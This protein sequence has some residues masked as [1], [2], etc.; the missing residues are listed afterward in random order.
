MPDNSDKF[1]DWNEHLKDVSAEQFSDVESR[2]LTKLWH[3]D[4]DIEEE[5]RERVSSVA[6]FY[7]KLCS[8]VL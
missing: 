3:D 7:L 2:L 8:L 4:D 1:T 5:L 6:V